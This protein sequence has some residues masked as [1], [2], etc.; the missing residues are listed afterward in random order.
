[1]LA[2][3]ECRPSGPCPLRLHDVQGAEERCRDYLEFL[4]AQ[5]DLGLDVVVELPIAP[6]G[7]GQRPLQPA[8][9][10]GDLSTRGWTVSNGW[11]RLDGGGTLLVKEYHTPDG[12]LRTEIEKPSD[13]PYGEH[14]PFL[15]DYIIPCA[16]KFLV[17]AP[18]GPGGAALPAGAAH[19]RRDHQ[20]ISRKASPTWSWRRNAGCW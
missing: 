10:A 9:S 2:A 15:D 4:R 1:M 20:L 11:N 16:R 12:V 19:R 7:G 17:R 5:L 8:R 6:A 14:V 13:W 3:L 18:G